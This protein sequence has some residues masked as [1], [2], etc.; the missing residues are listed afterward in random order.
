M[1]RYKSEGGQQKYDT[2]PSLSFFPGCERSD[3]LIPNLISPVEV[4]KCRPSAKTLGI[5]TEQNEK[6]GEIQQLLENKS[7]SIGELNDALNRLRTDNI[8]ETAS[9]NQKNVEAKTETTRTIEARAQADAIQNQK[10]VEGFNPLPLALSVGIAGGLIWNGIGI[11]KSNGRL[12]KVAKNKLENQNSAKEV[13]VHKKDQSRFDKFELKHKT[14][15]QELVTKELNNTNG[16]ESIKTELKKQFKGTE[17]AMA[18]I[19]ANN[20]WL[21]QQKN[22]T[23][24]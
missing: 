21:T 3:I 20:N 2:V 7:T 10:N 5:L 8:T 15:I 4:G 18:L 17:L 11:V 12:N 1:I 24:P 6:S 16:L 23:T 14:K 19:Y 13:S 22:K 9:N